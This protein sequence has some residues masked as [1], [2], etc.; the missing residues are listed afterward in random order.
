MLPVATAPN[1]IVYSTGQI[2]I[3]DMVRRGLRVNLMGILIITLI[4]Y[5]IAPLVL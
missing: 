4:G 3:Q 2:R 5:F 1:A